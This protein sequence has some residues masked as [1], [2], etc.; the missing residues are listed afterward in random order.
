MLENV[1][2]QFWSQLVQVRN[3]RGDMLFVVRVTILGRVVGVYHLQLMLTSHI[4]W[5]RC[6]MGCESNESDVSSQTDPRVRSRSGK[7]VCV[8]DL[9]AR[10]GWVDV[11]F[12]QPHA[13][14]RRGLHEVAAISPAVPHPG[15]RSDE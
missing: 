8:K 9:G 12:S 6:G 13:C 10:F 15:D 2:L 4:A 7:A 11:Q 5:C 1:G 3:A 14:K